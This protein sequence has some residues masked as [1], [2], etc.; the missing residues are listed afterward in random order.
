MGTK[1]NSLTQQLQ[2]VTFSPYIALLTLR[3]GKHKIHYNT[4]LKIKI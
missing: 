2:T 4:E 1:C 3:D